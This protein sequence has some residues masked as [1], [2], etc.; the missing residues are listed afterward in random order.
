MNKKK[1]RYIVGIITPRN[2]IQY[3]TH[4]DLANRFTAWE[5]YAKAVEMPLG[6][7]KEVTAGLRANGYD[8]ILIREDGERIY[9]NRRLFDNGESNG[10][11]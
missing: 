10:T 8:A 7:A 3:L 9:Y 11:I 5:G 4:L 6:I 1:A 2:Y